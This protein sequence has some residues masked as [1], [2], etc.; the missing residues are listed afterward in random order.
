MKNFVITAALAL[1]FSFTHTGSVAAQ[2]SGSDVSE[3]AA[4]PLASVILAPL[5]SSAITGSIVEEAAVALSTSGGAFVVKTVEST[6][7]G[8]VL[9]MDRISD[10]TRVSIEVIGKGTAAASAVV[11]TT[12]A[13][14]VIGT[15]AVL[16]IA[17]EAIAFVPNSA[18]R[19]LL[20]N[21]R[22][23]N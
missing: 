20:H 13:V 23:T 21:E 15:G 14:S 4:L 19:A 10:G 11:G 9:V 5:G 1:C 22:V 18:G 12:V 6:V 7:R 17:G 3:R 2:N 8:T 16:S